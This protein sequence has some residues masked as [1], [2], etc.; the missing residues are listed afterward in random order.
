MY[1]FWTLK[2]KMDG[3]ET[4]H[5]EVSYEILQEHIN[6]L[7]ENQNQIIGR[8]KVLNK[9]VDDLRKTL[10]QFSEKILALEEVSTDGKKLMSEIKT[11]KNRIGELYTIVKDG[12]EEDLSID[13]EGQ[14]IHADDAESCHSGFSCSSKVLA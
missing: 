9:N 7:T 4:H 2:L 5:V 14:E 1:K 12:K 13:A 10:T 3:E 8:F 11:L 6:K